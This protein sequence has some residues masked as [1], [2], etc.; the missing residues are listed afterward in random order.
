[1]PCG[2][3]PQ[4]KSGPG[5]VQPKY[6]LPDPSPPRDAQVMFVGASS[7]SS[8]YLAQSRFC[9]VATNPPTSRRYLPRLSVAVHHTAIVCEGR[10][11]A[12]TAPA[13]LSA[14]STVASLESRALGS[15]T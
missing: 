12:P 1:M 9:G 5:A 8:S 11:T 3:K 4:T 6:D 13:S 15:S 7:D 14:P 10:A 2:S